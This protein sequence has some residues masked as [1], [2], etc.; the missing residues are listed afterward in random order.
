M[1]A[2]ITLQ[3][4]R[5][6]A[7]LISDGVGGAAPAISAAAGLG[8]RRPP[9]LVKTE[10]IIGQTKRFSDGVWRKAITDFIPTY[11][12]FIAYRLFRKSRP[13]IQLYLVVQLDFG[14]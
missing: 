8:E 7:L 14:A 3:P 4:Y 1:D 6:G 13:T 11:V 5:L 12:L 9:W 10:L 2:V